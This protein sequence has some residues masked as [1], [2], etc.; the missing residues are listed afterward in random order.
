[1]NK[2]DKQTDT[3]KTYK[4]RDRHKKDRLIKTNRQTDRQTHQDKYIY[5]YR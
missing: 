3:L 1:M 2:T 4:Q 5:T